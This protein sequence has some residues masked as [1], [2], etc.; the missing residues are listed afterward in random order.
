MLR[1]SRTRPA[2]TRCPQLSSPDPSDP[3]DP[4]PLSEPAASRALTPLL[5]GGAPRAEPSGYV[6]MLF[7][8]VTIARNW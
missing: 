8:K 1:A 5:P 6:T 7:I 4:L 3:R 2:N